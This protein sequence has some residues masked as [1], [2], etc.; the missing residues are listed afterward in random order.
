MEKLDKVTDLLVKE[1]IKAEIIDSNELK[2][3]HLKYDHTKGKYVNEQHHMTLFR[4]QDL[5]ED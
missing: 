5:N 2:A 3:M 1:M 4:I